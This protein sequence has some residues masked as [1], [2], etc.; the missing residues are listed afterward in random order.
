MAS[1]GIEMGIE[2]TKY[3]Q[4]G[5]D[6][7]L[8]EAANALKTDSNELELWC[9]NKKISLDRDLRDQLK[10]KLEFRIKENSKIESTKIE[11]TKIMESKI[12]STKIKE[13]TVIDQPNP[14]AAVEQTLENQTD[15]FIS[16][17]VSS[18]NLIAEQLRSWLIENNITV[19]MCSESLNAGDSFRSEI[20]KAVENCKLVVAL[21]NQGWCKSD[22]CKYEINYAMRLQLT[23]KKAF[24][25]S[26]IIRAI[27]LE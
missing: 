23:K 20:V 7:L 26:C 2:D 21:V 18:A 24:Y 6:S 5:L 1:Y 14:I 11:S 22:E 3:L 4:S 16:Y 10:V 8:H 17:N 9:G 12:E 25:S 15:V 19:W 27:R 13:S